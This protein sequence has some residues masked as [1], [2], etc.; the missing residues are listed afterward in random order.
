MFQSITATTISDA[1]INYLNSESFFMLVTLV[2]CFALVSVISLFFG[3]TR[4]S[5]L[6]LF[7]SY[8]RPWIQL[9]PQG[10]L[11]VFKWEMV[12]SYHNLSAKG[13]YM[14]GAIQCRE[15]GYIYFLR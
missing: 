8:P 5:Q 9:F 15:L 13:A 1:Q 4:R 3:V 10:L 14:Q 11:V 12:F 6:I 2:V 7:I